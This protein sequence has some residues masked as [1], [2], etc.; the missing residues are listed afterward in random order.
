M[1]IGLAPNL[2]LKFVFGLPINLPNFARLDYAFTNYSNFL[3]SVQKEEKTKKFFQ[4]FDCSC[5]RN[6]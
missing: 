1:F 5:F 2:M 4:K 6:N 3:S